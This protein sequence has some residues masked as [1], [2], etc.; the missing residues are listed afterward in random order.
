MSQIVLNQLGA[1]IHYKFP[2]LIYF[3]LCFKPAQGLFHIFTRTLKVKT[4]EI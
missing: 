3:N 4:E 2:K 1:F